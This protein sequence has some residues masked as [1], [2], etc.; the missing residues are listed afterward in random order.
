MWYHKRNLWCSESQASWVSHLSLGQWRRMNNQWS[1]VS[2]LLHQAVFMM[3]SVFFLDPAYQRSPS[4]HVLHVPCKWWILSWD[5]AKS[6]RVSGSPLLAPCFRHPSSRFCAVSRFSQVFQ[7]A[8]DGTGQSVSCFYWIF[9]KSWARTH[10]LFGVKAGDMVVTI[11]CVYLI[12]Q[13]YWK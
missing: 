1:V 9:P 10:F 3:T 11:F 7:T 8:V 5:E 13:C 12:S 6:L 4:F 2:R